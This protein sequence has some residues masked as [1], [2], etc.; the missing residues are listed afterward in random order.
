MIEL[1]F[2]NAMSEALGEKGIRE[3]DIEALKDKAKDAHEK[4][5]GRK[6]PGLSFIDLKDADL[7]PI[8]DAARALREE[9]EDFI[10]LGIGG[11]GLGPKTILEALSPMHN[12]FRRPR[13]F[14]CD[15]VDPMTLDGVLRLIEP[16]KTCVN[17]ITKSGSTAETMASFMVLSEKIKP[18]RFI[19]TTDPEKGNLRRI[20]SESGM[21][22]LPVPPGVGG[23][24]SV[25]S[26]VGLLLAE[27]IGGFAGG[28]LGGARDMHRR[29]TEPDVWKNPAYL[30][31]SIL[32]LMDVKHKR[33]IHVMAPYS[34]RLKPL[35]EW[36]CQLWAESLGKS[37]GGPTPYPSLGTVDQHSQLQ[38]WMEGPEDKVIVF[39]RVGDHGPDVKIPEVFKGTDTAYLGGHSLAGLMNAEEEST[40]LCLQRAG[41]PNMTL[42]VPSINAESLGGM[43]HLLGLSTA[44]AGFLY[45][46]DP[47]DQPAVETGKNFTYG[48]MG[49]KG[50]EAMKKEVEDARRKKECWR[51]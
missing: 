12:Y 37:G 2:A 3:R 16:E 6:H 8:K 43:F 26:P 42:N 7:T 19:A 35:S 46:I 50:F 30:L 29:C 34:D 13:V 14:I 27:A 36:F 47:F 28:L 21:R 15:N 4:I 22:T 5:A 45:G 31:A 51:L 20:A 18:S 33:N 38:L 39:V 23:R 11:S 10:V 24:Y 9:C 48:M 17:V 49:R 1:N 32:Y 44:F 25:L 40:E 41:R